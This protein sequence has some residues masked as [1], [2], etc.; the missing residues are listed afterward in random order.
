MCIHCGWRKN[1]GDGEFNFG[2]AY[3]IFPS[4]HALYV[5]VSE[6]LSDMG[7]PIFGEC[8]SFLPKTLHSSQRKNIGDWES[9]F[10]GVYIIFATTHTPY[11]VVSKKIWEMGY[12]ILGEQTSFL[13]LHI[14]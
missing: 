7:D 14:H 1:I 3:I 11:I 5:V 2:G 6:K 8:T 4:S 13:R 10:G 9:N 12:S